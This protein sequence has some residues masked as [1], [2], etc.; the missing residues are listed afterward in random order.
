MTAE[1]GIES[2]NNLMSGFNTHINR[3][4]DETHQISEDWS[5]LIAARGRRDDNAAELLKRLLPH[6]GGI[7]TYAKRCRERLEAIIANPFDR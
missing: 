3:M 5:G 1:T 7:E 2:L 6:L 4:S